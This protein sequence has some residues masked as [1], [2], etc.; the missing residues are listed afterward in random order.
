[1]SEMA[2][3]RHALI[4]QALSQS[5]GPVTLRAL[6]NVTGLDLTTLDYTLGNMLRRGEVKRTEL[7]YRKGESKTSAF[8]WELIESV[9]Q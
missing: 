5:T 1:M 3:N 8:A 2:K 4:N 7:R 6:G 9:N